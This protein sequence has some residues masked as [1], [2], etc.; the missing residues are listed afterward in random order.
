MTIATMLA[1]IDLLPFYWNNNVMVNFT[2]H[3]EAG[4]PV[5]FASV[6]VVTRATRL[7]FWTNYSEKESTY[8]GWTDWR[9]KRTLF[10]P[11]YSA[12]FWG[13]VTK[14]GY[15]EED[16]VGGEFAWKGGR[17]TPNLVEHSKNINVELRK[18]H[19]PVKMYVYEYD[20]K[21]KFNPPT[22]GI[23][24]IEYDFQKGWALPPYGDG[25]VD[26]MAAIVKVAKH[27]TY[28]DAKLCRLEFPHGGAY[29]CE[30]YKHGQLKSD[31]EANPEAEYRKTLE[32]SEV[33]SCDT[34]LV[35]R[36][37]ERRDS[38]GNLVSAQYGK[39]QGGINIPKYGHQ[40]LRFSQCSLNPTPNDLS[41]ECDMDESMDGRRG[42]FLP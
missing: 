30:N 23:Y 39:I 40:E 42:P 6:H 37:R 32:S 36:V 33:A 21:D 34:H 27:K 29:V 24:R 35:F 19:R 3:D 20:F 9:G 2:V 26:D 16:D 11:C 4:S 17:F 5:P 12:E 28:F 31:Y 18:K 41:L 13:Y 1:M 22:N 8:E 25:E 38:E 15:Y 14:N 10:F 7:S